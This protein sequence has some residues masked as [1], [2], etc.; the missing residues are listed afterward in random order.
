MAVALVAGAVA[1]KPHSGGAAWTRVS[2][3]LGLRRLGFDVVFVEEI[4]PRPDVC[5]AARWFTDVM[6]WAGLWPEVTLLARGSQLTL[7][8]SRAELLERAAEAELLVNI[9]GHLRDAEIRALPRRRVLVDLDPGYTQTW[10][11]KGL[12][13]GALDGHD[14][15][16]TVGE[17]IGRPDCPIPT[18][19]IHWR[20]VRQP[21]LLDDWP[22]TRG[23]RDRFTTVASW[24]GP[25]GTIDVEGSPRGGKVHE[26]R[27][28]AELPRLVRQRCEI[29]LEIDPADEDD[30]WALLNHGWQLP[31]PREVAGT[32]EAFRTYVQAS[33]AELSVAQGVY[34][35]GRTG[36]IS[37]RTVRYL[38]SG[39]PA[40]VQDTAI[41]DSLRTG[42]GL[43][44]FTTLEEAV[45]GAAAIAADY[46]RHSRAARAL[47]E[48]HFA[49]DRVL[50][51][52][53][54]AAEVAA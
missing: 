38:A 27:R 14:E 39:K 26:F 29:A 49:S 11:A 15:Y 30:R 8:L 3:A 21:V 6:R 17:R 5:V 24:R 19:D 37:D 22:V 18:G 50:G 9:S 31:S 47:A 41:D 12:D 33:G 44:T 23:D 46:E 54:E 52:L 51:G 10:H 35:A 25:L 28:F 48:E 4:D 43:L 13:P 42:A 45:A 1:N 2:W 34:V 7:G 16:L 36:W 40:L 20:P 32:P 53:L